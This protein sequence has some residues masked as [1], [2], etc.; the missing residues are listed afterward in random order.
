MSEPFICPELTVVMFCGVG[1]N[2]KG[3]QSVDLDEI[4]EVWYV[5]TRS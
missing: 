2:G 1:I 3:E 4:G 5:A